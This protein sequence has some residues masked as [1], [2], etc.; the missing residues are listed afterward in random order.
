MSESHVYRYAC[1]STLDLI[2]ALE[3][4]YVRYARTYLGGYALN[5]FDT[6]FSTIFFCAHTRTHVSHKQDACSVELCLKHTT[7]V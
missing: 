3:F 5:K 4:T 6:H 7:S 2:L 1:C